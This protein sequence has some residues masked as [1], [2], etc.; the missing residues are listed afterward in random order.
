MIEIR[1]IYRILRD[2]LKLRNIV[3]D[4]FMRKKSNIYDFTLQINVVKIMHD[5][6]NLHIYFYKIY[7]ML[8]NYV[9]H[10]YVI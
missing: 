5:T 7:K 1:F 9:V 3:I 10:F 4:L 8:F 6:A 2:L